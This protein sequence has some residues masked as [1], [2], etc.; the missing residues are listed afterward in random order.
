VCGLPSCRVEEPCVIWAAAC[1]AH[2]IEEK[3]IAFLLPPSVDVA[4]IVMGVGKSGRSCDACVSYV[5]V[6][7]CS[8]SVLFNGVIRRCSQD[9][10]TGQQTNCVNDT[11]L[12]VR[13]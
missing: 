5:V 11:F 2:G 13:F 4:D 12:R 10:E 9:K 3:A 1:A 8:V 7:C 6:I